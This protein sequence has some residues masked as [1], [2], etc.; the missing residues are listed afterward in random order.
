MKPTN[1]FDLIEFQQRA[2]VI[3][4]PEKLF[5]LW[6]DVCNRYD[7]GEINK[8]QLEEMKSIVEPNLNAFAVLRRAIDRIDSSTDSSSSGS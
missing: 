6:V 3:A 8:L 2:R 4:S 5:E 1:D 7:R